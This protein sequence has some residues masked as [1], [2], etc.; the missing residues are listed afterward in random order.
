LASA[1]TQ[2]GGKPSHKRQHKHIYNL[3]ISIYN[4]A[5]HKA[6]R[7]QSTAAARSVQ[8]TVDPAWG[9]GEAR[10][11]GSDVVTGWHRGWHPCMA[12][13]EHIW[14]AELD[15]APRAVF[16]VDAT[17]ANTRLQLARTP[18]W[19]MSDPDDVLD[20]WWRWGNPQLCR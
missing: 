1:R 10:I 17:G 7:S 4:F 2:I 9:E 18:I 12:Q 14:Q 15:F 5:E 20:K 6:Q 3:Q 13:S 16:M 11:C 8:L 19:Q